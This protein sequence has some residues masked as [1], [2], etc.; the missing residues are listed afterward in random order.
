MSNI[1]KKQPE[2]IGFNLYTG[3]TDYVFDWIKKYKSERASFILK[4]PIFLH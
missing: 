3:L 1:K 4:K 2:W